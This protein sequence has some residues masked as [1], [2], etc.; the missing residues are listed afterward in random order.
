MTMGKKQYGPV[1]ACWFGDF[2][3]LGCSRQLSLI[4]KHSIRIYISWINHF[5]LYVGPL[6]IYLNAS[7]DNNTLFSFTLFSRLK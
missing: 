6:D 2:K 7:Q 3:F 5:P 1:K 4:M